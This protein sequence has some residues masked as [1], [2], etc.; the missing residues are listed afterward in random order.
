[1]EANSLQVGLMPGRLDISGKLAGVRY[2]PIDIM[3][4]KGMGGFFGIFLGR[5]RFLQGNRRQRSGTGIEKILNH[6]WAG[7]IGKEFN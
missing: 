2:L 6:D 4:V 3:H 7:F 5:I 1:V